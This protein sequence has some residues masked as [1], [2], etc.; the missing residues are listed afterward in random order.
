M[1][2]P[3]RASQVRSRSHAAWLISGGTVVTMDPLLGDIA[4]CDVLVRNGAIVEIGRGL[5]AGDA[6][7]IDARDCIVMPGLIDTHWHMWNTLARGL[8]RSA[9]GGF[10]P[11]MTALAKVWTPDAAALGVRLALAEAVDG[12]I[13]CAVNWAHNIRSPAHARAEFGAMDESG[14]R[15][16]FSYG[17]PNDLPAGET[18]DVADLIQLR[19][20]AFVVRRG[21]VGLGVCVRGPERS[22]ESVWRHEWSAARDLG[23]P[24]STHIA[25]TRE[26]AAKRAVATLARDGLLGRDIQLVHATHATAQDFESIAA[27]GSPLSLSPWTELEVGYGVPPVAAAMRAGVR[28][29]LS[30]DNQMLAGRADMFAVMKL[31]ADIASGSEQNQSAITN[32]DALRWATLGGAEDLGIADAVGSLAPG[33]RA[34]LI[35]VRSDRLG[36]APYASVDSLL[37][38]SAQAADVDFVMIDGVV[39]KRD[40]RLLRIDVPA[41]LREATREIGRMRT[42]ADV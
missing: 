31:A 2:A 39:H 22:D 5:A 15:G 28:L 35:M 38:H 29:S 27:A 9:K 14:V 20:E 10:Q 7:R 23:L 36:V 24:L 37:T 12:G 4:D 6:E 34:D 19:R 32:R 16:R 13:T 40:G 41:L 17:Y 30:V 21:L 11:T 33:K 26:A 18:M 42:A 1:P 25:T 3:D 8:S